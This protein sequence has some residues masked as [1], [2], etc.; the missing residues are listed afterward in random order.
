MKYAKMVDIIPEGMSGNVV[1]RH[2]EVSQAQSD[3]TM[4]RAAVNDRKRDYIPAGRYVRLF[5]GGQLY[6]SDTP[7]E[8]RENQELLDRARG[9]VLIAGIGM[10]LV[11]LLANP[12]V[13]SVTVVEMDPDVVALVAPYFPEVNV[14]TA[15]F[16]KWSALP[17]V[18]WDTIYFDIWPDISTDDMP[19]V[20][21]LRKRYRRRLN[22][23]GWMGE[24][25]QDLRR[26]QR[27]VEVAMVRE[28]GYS[29]ADI[30]LGTDP[31][32]GMKAADARR[33]KPPRRPPVGCDRPGEFVE[34]DPADMALTLFAMA[35]RIAEFDPEG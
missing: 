4:I 13:T 5:I 25:A 3:M 24:W 7:T 27:R 12:A 23:G 18:R 26:K 17:G 22:P 6:M 9:D 30:P 10:V 11:P 21:K 29:A 20:A 19:E 8:Q 1:V 35:R 14:V 15:D 31:V 32:E 33:G 2:G 34:C 28:H 16:L